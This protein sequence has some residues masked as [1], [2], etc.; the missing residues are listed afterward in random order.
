VLSLKTVGR[1]FASEFETTTGFRFRG[2]LQPVPEGSA[3]AS[4]LS[5][6]LWLK[7]ETDVDINAGDQIVD[8][9]GRRLLLGANDQAFWSDDPI[10]KS[11]RCFVLD[12]RVSW[13]RATLLTDTLT[14]LQHATGK[15]DLGMIWVLLEP[16]RSYLDGTLRVAPNNANL[17]T[18]ED[19]RLGDE[20]DGRIVKRINTVL[21]VTLAEIA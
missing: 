6:R 13:W 19:I 7:V 5:P 15:Q 2:T 3:N 4:F 8:P 20:I 11:F 9:A 21:G 12:H 18:G 17:L 14:G 1:R 10:Y 16:D